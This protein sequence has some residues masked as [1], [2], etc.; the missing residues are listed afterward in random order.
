MTVT[1]ATLTPSYQSKYLSRY[2][3]A[4]KAR[5]IGVGAAQYANEVWHHH[6]FCATV[7]NSLL[8]FSV[9]EL[10]FIPP[11]RPYREPKCHITITFLSHYLLVVIYFRF[12]SRF[13]AMVIR[14][15]ESFSDSRSRFRRH[16]WNKI[17]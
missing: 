3:Q 6:E 12:T 13:F 11:Q 15:Q 1:N 4:L 5:I 17:L 9:N 16:R 7:H 10:Y 8:L 14:S 2:A